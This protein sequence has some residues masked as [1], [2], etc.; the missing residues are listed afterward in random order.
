VTIP[1]PIA[2]F[3]AG[4][5]AAG[6]RNWHVIAATIEAIG[7]GKFSPE[8]LS[9]AAHAWTKASTRNLDGALGALD[10]AVRRVRGMGPS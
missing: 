5:H 10:G 1:D 6:T 7:L 8:A 2:A 3:A 4:I 9:V